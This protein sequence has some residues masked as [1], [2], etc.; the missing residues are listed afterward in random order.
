MHAWRAEP[1]EAWSSANEVMRLSAPGSTLWATAAMAKLGSANLRVA[2]YQETLDALLAVEP[3]KEAVAIIAYALAVAIFILDLE[4]HLELAG[5]ALRRLHAIVLPIA[6][7]DLLARAWMQGLHAYRDTWL[8]ED[9][10]SGLLASERAIA[11]FSAIGDL[12]MTR[13][14]QVF[15]GM[16]LWFL[17]NHPR[18]ERELRS[19]A[20]ASTEVELGVMAPLRTFC[21]VG[22]LADQGALTE[23]RAEATRALEDLG[24]QDGGIRGGCVRWALAEVLR[25]TGD[26][27]A[28]EREALAALARLADLPVYYAAAVA[29]LAAI[30]LAR[31][32]IAMA[33][34]DAERAMN[35]YKALGAFGFRGSFARLVHAEALRE[36]GFHEQ[37]RAALSHARGRLLSVAAGMGDRNL[38]WSRSFLEN[39]LENA[40]TLA[41]AAHTGD[42]DEP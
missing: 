13:V 36:A 17:G 14:N 41:T 21:L 1:A 30:R 10:L 31:G 39:V 29:T 37:A 8:S 25:R 9:P 2:G 28:A 23:A 32:N 20:V 27:E 5:A 34:A 12:R 15:A 3:A 35:H 22:V 16:N 24:A 26:L 18:A 40:R 6:E 38:A 33:L 42:G 11:D 7:V 19:A 4:G